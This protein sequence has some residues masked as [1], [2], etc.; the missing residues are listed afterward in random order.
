MTIVKK[1]ASIREVAEYTG[2]PGKTLYHWAGTGFLPSI[3]AGKKVM[4]DL[5]D[6]DDFMNGFKRNGRSHE[7]IIKTTVNKVISSASPISTHINQGAWLYNTKQHNQRLS[8]RKE[9][10]NV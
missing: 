5:A 7:E 3:K 10:D 6:V 1:Y 2:I 4:F 8:E 9:E